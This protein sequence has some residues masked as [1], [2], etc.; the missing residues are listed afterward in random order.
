ASLDEANNW[1]I[2][3]LPRLE[4]L[5]FAAEKD[6]AHVKEQLRTYISDIRDTESQLLKGSTRKEEIIR[7]SKMSKD[8]E[9]ARMLKAR[10]LGPEHLEVQSQLRREIRA[11]RE[12]L[13]QLEGHMQEAKKKLAHMKSGKAALRP[14][15]LSLINNTCNHLE[16]AIDQNEDAIEELSERTAHLSLELAPRR[17]KWD[18]R[19]TDEDIKRH[20]EATPNF[21]VSTAAALNAEVSANKLKRALAARKEPLLNTQAASKMPVA[22]DYV[23]PEVKEEPQTSDALCQEVRTFLT[24][25]MVLGAPNDA[26]ASS[27]E[28]Y[29]SPAA[30]HR[31]SKGGK[32]HQKPIQ[33]KK[34]GSPTPPPVS[35]FN[36]GPLPS[37]TPPPPPKA[38]PFD[39]RNLSISPSASPSPPSLSASWVTDGFNVKKEG[40]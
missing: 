23:L 24:K 11:V 28:E 4:Q 2:S 35:S 33:L 25:S 38:L 10:T 31:R 36:W 12:R 34:S 40:V 37:V 5:M 6:L 15:S 9:F 17:S 26:F 27:S 39:L 13:Q 1:R 18:Q 32:F 7:F 16:E 20:V 3:D 14:P 8:P 22:Q 21:A 29:S 30:G 19:I